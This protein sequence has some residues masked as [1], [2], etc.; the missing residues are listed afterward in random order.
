MKITESEDGLFATLAR[1]I[2]DPFTSNTVGG[3]VAWVKCQWCRL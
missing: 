2:T 3:Q 1:I